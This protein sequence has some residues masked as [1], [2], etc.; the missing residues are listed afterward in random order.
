MKTNFFV[1]VIGLGAFLFAIVVASDFFVVAV[2]DEF[3]S[4]IIVLP[5]RLFIIFV[6]GAE[7]HLSRI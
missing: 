7:I 3:F 4:D 5:G 6:M 1:V 2:P